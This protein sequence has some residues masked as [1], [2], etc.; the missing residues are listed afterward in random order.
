[1]SQN[2]MFDVADDC[3]HDPLQS[4]PSKRQSAQFNTQG[5]PDSQMP[6]QNF[7]NWTDIDAIPETSPGINAPTANP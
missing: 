6:K 4:D 7:I 5:T 2:Q 3:S 1:M